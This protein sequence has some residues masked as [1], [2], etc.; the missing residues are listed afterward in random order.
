MRTCLWERGGEGRRGERREGR[1]LER[2]V[3]GRPPPCPLAASRCTSG[4]LYVNLTELCQCAVGA[5]F[6]F[7]GFAPHVLLACGVVGGK[8]NGLA[9]CVV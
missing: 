2:A 4:D 3:C 8:M 1:A 9:K 7:C 5:Y 6:I